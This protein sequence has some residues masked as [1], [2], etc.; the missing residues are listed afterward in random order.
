VIEIVSKLTHSVAKRRLVEG[1]D[2]RST[3]GEWLLAEAPTAAE[4]DKLTE[5][6][7]LER[8][9]LDDAL[10]TDEIPRL[11]HDDRHGYLYVRFPYT[12]HDGRTTT[13]PLL[14]IFGTDIPL[15][16][17]PVRPTWLNEWLDSDSGFPTRSPQAV[18]L[19]LLSDVVADYD[20]YIKGQSQAVKAVITKMRQHKLVN[21]D[22]VRFVL[23]EDQINNFLSSLT[24]LVPLLRR[25]TVSKHLVW[26]DSER[27][28]LEDITLAV[29]QSIR[30]CNINS[31]RIVSIREAYAALSNNSLNRTMKAL[32]AATLFIALPNVIFGMY[33][34]NIDLPIQHQAWAFAVIVCS[35]LVAVALI[36][37]VAKRRHWF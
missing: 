28:I 5:K 26:T 29:E 6:F 4:L 3:N 8:G 9:N 17:F 18:I 7:S 37:F 33:G 27:D 30:I 36:I 2:W 35:T 10:D 16:I 25:L 20:T 31:A 24:P 23:I 14:T 15:T 12:H 21:E 13:R 1:D 32:T 11:D 34:M 19:K 22:F